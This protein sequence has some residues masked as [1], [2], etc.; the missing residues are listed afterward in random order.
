MPI[1]SNRPS[2]G[3]LIA[4]IALVLA[5][6]SSAWALPGRDKVDA[7]DLSKGSVTTRALA[8]GSVGAP[9][10]AAGAVGQS[11]VADA[12]IREAELG[13]ESVGSGELEQINQRVTT[14][15]VAAG[16]IGDANT[17]C[18]DTERLVSGGATVEAGPDAVTPLLSSGPNG[19]AG[20]AARIQNASAQEV[21]LTAIAL[22]IGQ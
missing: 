8:A 6:G 1:R 17:S 10:I 13:P 12:S 15:K 20:W 4:M 11:E 2:S 5:L 22:C 18:K 3:T 9:A 16:K 19:D 7:N 14:V 21:S